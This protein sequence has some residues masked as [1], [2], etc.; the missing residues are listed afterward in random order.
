MTPTIPLTALARIVTHINPRKHISMSE[1]I[2]GYSLLTLGLDYLASAAE[3]RKNDCFVSEEPHE[4]R[5]MERRFSRRLT[6][7]RI[8]I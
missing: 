1:L 8:C 4:A 6:D 5:T 2:Q 7:R 3:Q